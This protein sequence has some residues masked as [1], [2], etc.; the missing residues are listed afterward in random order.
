M[1]DVLILA[2]AVGAVSLAADGHATGRAPGGA[3]PE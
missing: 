1:A 3:G 2:M